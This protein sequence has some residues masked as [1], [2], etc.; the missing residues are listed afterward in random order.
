MYINFLKHCN[1]KFDKGALQ[2]LK[3]LF[4]QVFNIR[5]KMQA[6]GRGLALWSERQVGTPAIQVQPLV[7]TASILMY[8]TAL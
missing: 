3:I 2:F 8:A 7:G 6:L 4:S 5:I 1:T